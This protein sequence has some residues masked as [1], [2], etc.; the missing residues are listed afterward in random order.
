MLTDAISVLVRALSFVALFQAA[1]AGLFIALFRN[2]VA[3]SLSTIRRIGLV[4]ALAGVAFVTGHYLLEAARMAG[5]LSGVLDM[6]LQRLVFDSA[7][8]VAWAL[9]TLGLVL[10][11]VGLMRD[12]SREFMWSLLGTALA[13]IAFSLVGHTAAHIARGWLMVLLVAHL[14]VVAFWFGALAPLYVATLK[15][16]MPQASHVVERFSRL[17]LWLVPIIFIAGALMTWVLVDRWAAFTESYGQLLLAKVA[18]FT[19]LMGLAALNRWRLG[20]SMISRP[21]AVVSLRRAIAI[22]YVLIVLVL[23]ITALM[24][25]LFSPE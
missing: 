22:E 20:P 12:G 23:M 8:S 6:S 16:P 15:E 10:I 17:A 7:M 9:R 2:D 1:G 21:G 5:E 11:A 18:G 3:N 13:L 25:T 19:L 24:T 4:S 14:L